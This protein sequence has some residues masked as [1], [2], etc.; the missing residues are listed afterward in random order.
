MPLLKTP[1]IML[2]SRK[3]RDADRL[4]TVYTLRFGKIRGV[5]RGA[6]RM[7]SRFGSALEPFVHADLNLFQKANDPV[8]RI[9]QADIREPFTELRED[10]ELM[11]AAGRLVNLVAALTGEGDAGSKIFETLLTGLRAFESGS[12][13]TLTSL[14]FQIRL[15]RQ[16]GFAPQ[17]HHCAACGRAVEKVGGSKGYPFSPQSGGVVCDACAPRYQDRCLPLSPAGL[18]LVHHALEWMPAALTRLKVSPFVREEV[19]AAIEAYT[20]VVAGR[21][22]PPTDFLVAE[23]SAPRYSVTK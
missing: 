15:L 9:T 20:T 1:A 7:K 3:W 4:V 14:V 2:K 18:S 10:L 8:Y 13:P 23:T 12:D 19:Q 21:Q 11:A 16:A 22:L 17:L 5:A 6:R